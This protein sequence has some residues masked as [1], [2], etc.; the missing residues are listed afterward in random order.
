MKAKQ[1]ES[2]MAMAG[3]QQQMA[4]QNAAS[5]GT[6][7][8]SQFTNTQNQ[9]GDSMRGDILNS[10][11][12]I[13]INAALQNRQGQLSALG[14]S[15]DVLNGQVGR[16]GQQYQS[17][18]SGQSAMQGENQARFDNQFKPADFNMQKQLQQ[19]ALNKM[20]VDS[21]MD[22]Y[23]TDLGAFFDW[24]QNLLGNKTADNQ[25]KLGEA[26]IAT[27]RYRTDIQNEQF[28]KTNQLNWASL[29]NDM[30]MGRYGLGIDYAKLQQQGQQQTMQNMGF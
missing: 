3:Q 9:I 12:D 21:N 19:E 6:N 7:L 24:Q 2:A 30:Q 8:D 16:Q 1:R 11:R 20:G 17:Y 4:A 14:M 23:K 22:A 15:N 28:G 29:L 25:Y 26:G 13:D 5:R 18:L 27:D 10:Y